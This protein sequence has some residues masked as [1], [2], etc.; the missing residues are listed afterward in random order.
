MR[1]VTTPGGIETIVSYREFEFLES[2]QESVYKKDLDEF[3][4]EMARSLT[5]RGVLNRLYDDDGIYYVRNKNKGI[6]N[7]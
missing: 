6:E 7:G 3:T 5:T 4:A 1:T 2:I